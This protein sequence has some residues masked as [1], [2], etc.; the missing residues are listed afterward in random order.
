MI[1]PA[2]YG[3]V[4]DRLKGADAQPMLKPGFDLREWMISD[5]N[6]AL[7]NGHDLIMT[8]EWQGNVIEI[9]WLMRSRGRFALD[10]GI[11]FLRYLFQEKDARVVVGTTPALMRAARWFARQVGGTSNGLIETD[12]GLVESFSLTRK[13]FE[14][15]HGLSEIKAAFYQ[16]GAAVG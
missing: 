3:E 2:T 5:C 15:Q 6:E 12:L 13:D 14:A 11:D 8:T 9:H 7:T 1:R 16:H 4:F 10:A